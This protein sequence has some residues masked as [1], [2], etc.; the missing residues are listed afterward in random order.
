MLK[1]RLR[2]T[3]AGD[4][5]GLVVTCSFRF[6]VRR[7][8]EVIE[9]QSDHHTARVCESCLVLLTVHRRVHRMKVEKVIAEM[10]T[11]VALVAEV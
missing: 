4:A 3:K 8:D 7:E 1:D 6:E 9:L 2:P 10:A 5:S 11:P